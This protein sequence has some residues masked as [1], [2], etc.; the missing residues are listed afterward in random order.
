MAVHRRRGRRPSPPKVPV[1]V[2]VKAPDEL[3]ALIRAIAA[4]ADGKELKKDLRRSIRVALKPAA[5]S[6][7]ASIRSMGTT[8]RHYGTPL[9]AAIAK[10]VSIQVQMTRKTSGA[11]VRARTTPMVRDFRHAAKYTNRKKWRRRSFGGEEWTD[12]IG[13]PGW[14]DDAMKERRDEYRRAVI[15]AMEAMAKRISERG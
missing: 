11:S 3:H 7:K 4:E 8:S 9:R 14:F 10:K 2:H 12:Q 6:A 5:D 1:S 13:K 15:D